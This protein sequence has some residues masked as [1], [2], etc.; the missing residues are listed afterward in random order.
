MKKNSENKE[1]KFWFLGYCH[2][3]LGGMCKISNV[4]LSDRRID[5]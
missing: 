5:L 1:C 4:T 3:F 2:M